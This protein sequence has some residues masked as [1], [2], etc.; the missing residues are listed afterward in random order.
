M[1]DKGPHD[2]LLRAGNR[3]AR[4]L[5]KRYDYMK[6]IGPD[7]FRESYALLRALNAWRAAVERA[8]GG[9]KKAG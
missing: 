5:E 8:R 3:L 2:S 6:R 1:K 4:Y 7:G 9:E